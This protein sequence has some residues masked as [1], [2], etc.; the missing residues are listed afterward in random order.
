MVLA[1]H[2]CDEV[3]RIAADLRNRREA[4]EAKTVGALDRQRHVHA[5]DVVEREGCIEQPQ[6]RAD[7]ATRVVV[8][9]LAEQQRRTALD[10][11]QIDVVAERGPDDPAGRRD[12]E[13]YLGLR[14]VPGRYRM[15]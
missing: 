12:G 10:V 15:N 4:L 2:L 11:P 14:I 5:A 13:H 3:G 6:E 9:A 8:L 1:D 7:R